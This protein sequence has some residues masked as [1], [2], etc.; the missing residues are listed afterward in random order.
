MTDFIIVGAGLAG[1]MF[2]EKALREGRTFIIFE[3]ESQHSSSVAAGVY[4]PVSLKRLSGISDAQQQ[5]DTMHGY[6]QSIASRLNQHF[7][8]P[9]PLLRRFASIEEQNN[10]FHACEKPSLNAFL[11]D[12]LVSESFDGII[13]PFGFGLVKH[14]GWVNTRKL[15]ADFRN[16]LA[17]QQVLIKEAFVHSELVFTPQLVSYREIDARHIVFAE[18]FGMSRNPFFNRLPLNGTK[19]EVL[20]IEAPG[21]RADAIVKADVFLVP[22]GNYTY[23][24]GATYNWSDKSSVPTNEGRA[25]LEQKL[26]QL[27]DCD[28]KIISHEAG[29]RPTT[30]DRKPLLGTHPHFPALHLLNG[31]GTRG[32]ML[33][34]A[35]ANL[36]Y[37]HIES[38]RQLPREVDI[39]R[40]GADLLP[41]DHS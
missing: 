35:M 36:L 24:V 16:Y 8:N 33:G 10:W 21:I 40:F 17:S 37:D 25:E 39:N 19:G 23:R 5:L 20:V 11:S 18:G 22:L 31:L 34:P 41:A 29:I 7:D 15:L 30:K 9:T 4:N 27:I 1:L 6:L 28:F 14:T 13:S 32:V 12:R 38:R 2:A 26:R 3:D